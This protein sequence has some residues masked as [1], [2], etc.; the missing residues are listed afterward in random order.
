MTTKA[1]LASLLFCFVSLAFAQPAPWY[2]WKSKVNG[3]VVCLQTSPGEGWDKL[4]GPYKDGKCEKPSNAA[5]PKPT[6]QQIELYKKT[7]A[8]NPKTDKAASE[9]ALDAW[10]R[11][12]VKWSA[13]P[14]KSLATILSESQPM[15]VAAKPLGVDECR[16]GCAA[17]CCV[18]FGCF[19]ECL[20]G[21]LAGCK[22]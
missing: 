15:G 9:K 12:E 18:L 19:G 21:C 10:R 7:I 16:A 14:D 3:K 17:I 22:E 8:E 6:A 1:I 5:V 20:V 13:V 11:G 2:K 4:D